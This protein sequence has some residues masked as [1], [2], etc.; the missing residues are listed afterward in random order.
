MRPQNHEISHFL[1]YEITFA[2]NISLSFFSE[3]IQFHNYFHHLNRIGCRVT[4]MDMNMSKHSSFLNIF[5]NIFAHELLSFIISIINFQHK[6]QEFISAS[7]RFSAKLFVDN[8]IL[9]LL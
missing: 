8:E 7:D 3:Q 9:E 5:L 1:S 2:T 4:T 6:S